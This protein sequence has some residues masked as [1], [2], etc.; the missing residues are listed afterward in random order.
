[1]KTI[2][3]AISLTI[4][5]FASFTTKAQTYTTTE[6]KSCGACQGEV[7]IHSSIGDKCPHCGVRWGRKTTT[8][9]TSNNSFNSYNNSY[10][11]DNSYNYNYST[12]MTNSKCNVRSYPSTSAEV[13]GKASAYQSFEVI[14]VDGNW[15]QVKVSL[16][17]S[18]LGTISSFGWIHKSL[19]TLI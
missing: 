18:Y 4:L 2:I 9:T 5:N 19:V 7:S 10:N 17:D 6:S 15:V 8:Q 14:T 12:A 1:M 11:F 3:L 13:L 16:N